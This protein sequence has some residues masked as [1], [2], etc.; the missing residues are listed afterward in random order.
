M[1]ELSK[2]VDDDIWEISKYYV[3]LGEVYDKMLKE[4]PD[5]DVSDIPV[6]TLT[7]MIS[8]DD[9]IYKL[10]K[11]EDLALIE[12]DPKQQPVRSGEIKV[13]H[14]T[15]QDLEIYVGYSQMND[16]HLGYTKVSSDGILVGN[17]ASRH[18]AT[19]ALG[20]NEE[21]LAV[22]GRWEEI[23]Q[24]ISNDKESQEREAGYK[25]ALRIIGE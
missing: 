22:K 21:L 18:T 11:P 14:G 7:D 12:K 10:I 24:I 20:S 16:F 5:V 4:K 15:V 17:Y 9:T 3:F 23:A 6:E 2:K 25:K 1:L 8:N 13:F 19:K